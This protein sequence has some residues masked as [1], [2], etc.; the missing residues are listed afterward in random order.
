MYPKNSR[1]YDNATI[2]VAFQ[3]FS[4]GMVWDG[5]LA[6]KAGRDYLVE[7]GFAVRY[8]G[9]QA[10]TGKGV[11]AFLLHPITWRSAFRRWRNWARNPFVVMG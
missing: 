7:H 8:A 10:L 6:S 3:L 11:I 9:F 5:N 1:G 2:D 4:N